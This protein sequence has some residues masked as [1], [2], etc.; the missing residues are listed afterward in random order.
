MWTHIPSESSAE[1][2]LDSFVNHL[3]PWK[4]RFRCKTCGCTVASYNGKSEAWSIWGGQLER[5]Q[6]GSIK[7]WE[8]VKP[9]AHIF[10][11]TRMLDVSD[12]LGKWEG[13]EGKS[14][15]IL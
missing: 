14:Q 8:I 10:Y 12:D 9:T 5:D 3:K 1:S 4:T 13:Y 6:E 11:G 7:S 15:R 2:S